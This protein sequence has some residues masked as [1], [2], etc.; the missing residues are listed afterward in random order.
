MYYCNLT[1]IL[2]LFTPHYKQAIN[3]LK[4]YCIFNSKYILFIEFFFSPVACEA[5][6][7]GFMLH[8]TDKKSNVWTCLMN[9]I[10]GLHCMFS[11]TLLFNHLSWILHRGTQWDLEYNGTSLNCWPNSKWRS[12]LSAQ[13]VQATFV[14]LIFKYFAYD[15]GSINLWLHLI[16]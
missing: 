15:K 4:C 13:S 11:I 5:V 16:N 1:I 2:R 7:I 12:I 14:W 8:M 9:R 6:I 10:K 3:Q